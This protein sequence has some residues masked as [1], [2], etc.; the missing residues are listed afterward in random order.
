[1]HAGQGE[2]PDMLKGSIAFCPIR[3]ATEKK[4]NNNG[5]MIIYHKKQIKKKN[6]TLMSRFPNLESKQ[7]YL[8]THYLSDIM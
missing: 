4:K 8:H 7:I 2:A 6:Y 5:V 3:V 1:M